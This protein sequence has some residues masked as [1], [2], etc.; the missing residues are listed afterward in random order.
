MSVVLRVLLSIIIT[1]S[2]NAFAA[3]P[4]TAQLNQARING[5]AWLISH[6]SGDG[7]WKSTGGLAIQPTAAAL[8]ALTNA[9][10]KLGHP[11]MAAAAYL[12]N[13]DSASVDA[14]SRQIM[15]LDRAGLNV[16]PLV[17]KLN[18][19]QNGKSAWGAYSGY[20]SSL[21]DTPL[22]LSA[23]FQTHTLTSLNLP[24]TFA[25]TVCSGLL[26]A[27]RSDNSFSYLVNGTGGPAG[28]TSGT[29]L[30]TVYA[31]I[32]LNLVT[33]N[34]GW[35][36]LSCPTSYVLATVTNNALT[37]VISKQSATDGGFGDYGQST[38]LETAIAYLALQKLQPVTYA[39]QMG[40]AQGYLI[41]QQS[42]DGSWGGDPLATALAMQTLPILAPGTLADS[43]KSGIPDAVEV[44]LGLNPTSPN[45]SAPGNGQGVSGVTAAKLVA[46]GTQ[47][48]SFNLTLS[49][50]GGTV[51]YTWSVAS[52]YLP[53]GLSLNGVTG[54]ITGTPSTAGTFNFSYTAIDAL[55]S[56]STVAAQ[57]DIVTDNNDVP[58]LP[59]WGLIVMAAVLMGS[60]VVSNRQKHD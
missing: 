57:I 45:H 31:A 8:D 50:S 35:A 58:T 56:S 30:P 16:V 7:S 52:G 15:T 2:A 1:A 12:E 18:Q 10:I 54:Q 59:Q 26:A 41:A 25:T 21:P 36:S 3:A 32:A 42:A 49:A 29:L 28:Q 5:L 24:T 13:T 14:L 19:W 17:T 33:T 38:V 34:T 60:T 37:W 22:A 27:Q 11:Y 46:S 9:G 23:L 51:P 20:G 44:A 48:Q 53:D 55:N 40:N 43:N 39:T 6:Q 4:T 47:Y